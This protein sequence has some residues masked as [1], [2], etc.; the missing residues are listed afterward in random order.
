MKEIKLNLGCYD[1]PIPGYLGVDCRSEV[2]PD[3][4]DDIFKLES[5]EDG[6]ISILYA[7]HSL[8]HC[9]RDKL[10]PALERW[11]DVLKP[12]G[13]L[14]VAVPDF[15]SLCLRYL[16][17][18]DIKE[19]LHSVLGSAKHQ[20]DFHY[21]LF[22]F[23]YLKETLED[24]GFKDVKRYNWWETEHSHCD[25]FSRAYLPSDEP[26]ITLSHNRIILGKGKLV[27]LNIEACK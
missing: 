10:I 5:V 18:G 3:I 17:R 25:D 24:V 6:S 22:D 9:E 16:Y 15:E 27:S 1:R 4:I 12:G 11:R 2:N 23:K 13:V 7:S 26:D 20:F 14:R 8:E 21:H 19:V